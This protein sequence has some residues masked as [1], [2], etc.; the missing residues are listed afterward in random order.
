MTESNTK[1][2]EQL[3][4]R[5]RAI[6]A[7]RSAN[8]GHEVEYWIAELELALDQV[9]VAAIDAFYSHTLSLA[10]DR[11]NAAEERLAHEKA[12]RA[13][14]EEERAAFLTNLTAVQQ[15]CTELVNAKR[16]SAHF[17]ARRGDESAFLALAWNMTRARAKHP[18]GPDGM[19]SLAEE[20]GEV[21][22]AIRRE[23]LDRAREELLDLATVSMR[24]YVGEHTVGALQ[25]AQLVRLVVEG[26]SA[27]TE[28]AT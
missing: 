19:R 22:H 17:E 27:G 7:L 23:G 4:A 24:L 25:P 6:E 11:A 26:S 10:K 18:M 16:L 3:R 8:D 9:E 15:R 14:V 2:T 20:L 5:A 13:K 1:T 28:V 12:L 21:A